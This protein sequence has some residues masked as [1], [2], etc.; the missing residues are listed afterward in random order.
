MGIRR[1]CG[2]TEAAVGWSEEAYSVLRDWIIIW[3]A[4]VSGQSI[5]LWV[6]CNKKAYPMGLVEGG[7][8]QCPKDRLKYQ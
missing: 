8:Y 1:I 4:F 2:I 6:L 5:L 7:E 3:I